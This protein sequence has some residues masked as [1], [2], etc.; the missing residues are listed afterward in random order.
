MRVCR[1][2]FVA[3]TNI[4]VLV[5]RFIPQP[6]LLMQGEITISSTYYMYVPRHSHTLLSYKNQTG[7]QTI[8][9]RCDGSGNIRKKT[10][11]LTL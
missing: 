2:I 8:D 1:K 7:F 4:L 5:L 9:W 3:G 6:E 11:S 10:F